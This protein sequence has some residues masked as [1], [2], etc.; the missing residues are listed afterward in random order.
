[1]GEDPTNPR[2]SWWRFKFTWTG[3]IFLLAILGVIVAV[4]IPSYGDYIH[5]AQASEAFSLMDGARTALT[6]HFETHKKWPSKLEQ[7]T[8]DTS[9]KYALSVAIT[10][11]AGGTAELELTA[12]MKTDGVDRRVR[13][14]SVRILSADGGKT[15]I[16]R[17][18]TMELQYLPKS[19]R[20]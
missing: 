20:D 7:V 11:G 17:P 10:K 19:C 9:G 6:E 16:C 2:E 14:Q 3:L 8:P 15:W 18:G 12:T 1:M 13:G 4:A 5:K